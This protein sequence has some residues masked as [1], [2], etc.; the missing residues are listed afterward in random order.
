MGS[1]DMDDTAGLPRP[2]SPLH[3]PSAHKPPLGRIGMEDK[4][5]DF[6]FNPQLVKKVDSTWEKLT[7]DFH[8]TYHAMPFLLRLRRMKRSELGFHD[9]V[10]LLGFLAHHLTGQA[11]DIVEIGV[12]KGK[13]LA[14][15]DRLSLAGCKVVGVDPCAI[16]GQFRELS[17][18]H[19]ALFPR[20]DIVP[21]YS[22]FAIEQVL[23]HTCQIKLLHIDGDHRRHGVWLD[24]LLYN[25]YVVKGGYV[26]FDD[27]GDHQYSPEVGPAVDTMRSMNLF[28]SYEVIGQVEPF[29]DSFILRKC[30]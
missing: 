11:G 30:S 26:V 16:K 20:C 10:K 6:L 17:Y 5:L 3:G 19:K 12:W 18:F 15:M 4:S 8:A 2:L 24:F 7:Q 25:P 14:L 28:S 22:Q 13:S 27:Y 29:A 23:S 1:A 9:Q 21:R